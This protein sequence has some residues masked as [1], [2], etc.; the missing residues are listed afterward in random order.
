MVGTG[1]PQK[2]DAEAALNSATMVFWRQGLSATSLDDLAGAMDMNRPSIYRAFGNKDSIYRFALQNYGESTIEELD[3]LLARRRSLEEDLKLLFRQA[4]GTYCDGDEPLGCFIAC[5]ACADALTHPQLVKELLKLIRKIDRKLQERC[6][7]A[8]ESGEISSDFDPSVLAQAI[9]GV[10][11][12]LA[13][14]ARSGQQKGELITL[15]DFQ[16]TLLLRKSSTLSKT[17]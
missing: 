13:V 4:I 9:Q 1:R 11:H 15:A 6:C 3:K 2:Y 16:T 7:V 5:T 10:L 12:T 14:R 17:E 8:I